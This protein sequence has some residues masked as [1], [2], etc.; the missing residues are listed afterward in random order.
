MKKVTR[1][2]DPRLFLTGHIFWDQA[3]CHFNAQFPRLMAHISQV[4]VGDATKLFVPPFPTSEP[5]GILALRGSVQTKFDAI[6][7]LTS[8]LYLLAR[9][10]RH[11]ARP[12]EALPL[13]PPP[14]DEWT[15][16]SVH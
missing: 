14:G 6:Q 8:T 15:P 2:K 1:P 9:Y 16:P 5:F 7:D 3:L 12:E 4:Q 11:H 13:L 10:L